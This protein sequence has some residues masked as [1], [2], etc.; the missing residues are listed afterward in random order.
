VDRTFDEFLTQP[1]VLDTGGPIVYLGVMT[2]ANETGFWLHDAEVHDTRDGHAT[3]EVYISEAATRGISP[4]RRRVFVLRSAV[5]SISKL[6][7]VVTH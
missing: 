2:E 5:M 3:Q 4:N 6:E 1:V 7:D